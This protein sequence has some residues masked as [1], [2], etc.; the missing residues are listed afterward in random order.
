MAGKTLQELLDN[1]QPYPDGE[2][3]LI[4]AYDGLVKKVLLLLIDTDNPS[5]VIG[6]IIIESARI[7]KTIGKGNDLFR[8][9]RHEELVAAMTVAAERMNMDLETLNPLRAAMPSLIMGY[10]IVER[11]IR[12]ESDATLDALHEHLHILAV[13]VL[14]FVKQQNLDFDSLINGGMYAN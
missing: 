11:F 13:I 9:H 2:F 6:E 5:K 1:A 7:D 14:S 8:W 10:N 3:R 12:G 4:D